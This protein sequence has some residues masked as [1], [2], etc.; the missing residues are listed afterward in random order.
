[1]SNDASPIWRRGL[2][3]VL[4]ALTL[5]ACASV[6]TQRRPD[7]SLGPEAGVSFTLFADDDARAAGMPGPFGVIAVLE[8][9]EQ[10]RFQPLF[11]GV[12][13]QWAVT[14][15]EPGRYRIR[16]DSRLDVSGLEVPLSEATSKRFRARPGEMV[17]IEANLRHVS[18]GWVAA[19]IVAGVVAAVLLADWLHDKGLPA[20]PLPPPPPLWL[21][22][23]ALSVVL[24]LSMSR[25]AIE[26]H[27][28]KAPPFMV[29]T[30]L[31]APG[32]TVP[33]GLVSVV[34][35]FATDPGSVILSPEAVRVTADGEP[36]SG[37]LRWDDRSWR[38]VW[39]STEPVEPGTEIRVEVA[40]HAVRG[41]GDRELP[42]P[43]ST[44]FRVE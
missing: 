6:D 36:I 27:S 42:A 1:M 37:A 35:P 8:R 18:R 15:L 22:D 25:H 11:R 29:S 9:E 10:G 14:G 34:M 38:L 20:P 13:P 21:A 28:D 23:I 7:P 16:V 44:H 4:I 43:L 41:R 3:L 12:H 24:D 17:E 39:E 40:P 31:P 32:A 2:A 26:V 30:I 33:S 19:G 5:G